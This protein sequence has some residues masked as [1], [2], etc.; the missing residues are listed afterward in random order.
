MKRSTKTSHRTAQISSPTR[1]VSHDGPGQKHKKAE[2]ARGYAHKNAML[3]LAER[4][5]GRSKSLVVDNVKA[6]TLLPILRANIAKEAI[7]Y[8]DEAKG[9]YTPN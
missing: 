5:S 4:A 8:T 3:T 1:W 2:G 6:S 9:N 7:V